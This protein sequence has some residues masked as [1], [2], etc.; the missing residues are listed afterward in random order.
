MAIDE[1]GNHNDDLSV[2]FADIPQPPQDH[3]SIHP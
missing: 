2:N 1:K 3:D